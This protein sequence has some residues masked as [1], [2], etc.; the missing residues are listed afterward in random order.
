MREIGPLTTCSQHIENSIK[1]L[2]LGVFTLAACPSVY[3][4]ADQR[5]N[6]RPFFIGKVS[7]IS[8]AHRLFLLYVVRRKYTQIFNSEKVCKAVGDRNAVAC[9]INRDSVEL[10]ELLTSDQQYFASFC[11]N[12]QETTEDNKLVHLG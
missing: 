2:S 12:L 1:L 5:L 8:F 10:L 3:P 7:R 6:F 4:F 11:F 9:A